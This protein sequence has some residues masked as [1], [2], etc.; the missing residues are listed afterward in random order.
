LKE[1]RDSIDEER[2]PSN[3]SSLV[4]TQQPAFPHASPTI[5]I[6]SLSS[7]ILTDNVT[8]AADAVHDGTS[9]LAD[10][11]KRLALSPSEDRLF[12]K[13]SGDVLIQ[14]AMELKEGYTQ[15]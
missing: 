5:S 1:L 13:S 2:V 14:A 12:G 6:D 10:N 3:P 9:V 8:T 4:A 7:A 11:L 15:S